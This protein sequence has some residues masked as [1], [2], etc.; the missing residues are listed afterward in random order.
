MK[1]FILLAACALFAVVSCSKPDQGDGSK[2]PEPESK[3]Y[4]AS[5]TLND[6]K[7]ERPIKNGD[8][9]KTIDITSGGLFLLGYL[10]TDAIKPETAPL[11]YKSGKY[12]IVQVKTPSAD[13]KFTFGMYGSLTIK[14]DNGNGKWL[15]EYTEADGTSHEGI[16]TLNDEEVSG[17]LADNLCRS[18]KPTSIIVS[19]SGGDLTD[20]IVGKKFSADIN[21]II[22]YLKE[23]GVDINPSNYAQYQLQSID[24]AENGLIIINFKDFAIAPFVGNFSLN[25][26][27]DNNIAYNFELSWEDNP[28]IPVSG[29]GS[30]NVNGSQMTLYTESD[31]VIQGQTYYVSV[32]IISDEIK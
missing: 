26:S 19:A 9:P 5:F 3:S 18:W 24:Y 13:L 21:E 28:V 20:A 27:Q 32:T 2:L 29:V 23:K 16:A 10:D 31:A 12:G 6:T 11:K 17:A 22:A 7:L 4:H 1:R 30:V 8:I 14:K 25:E 15:I